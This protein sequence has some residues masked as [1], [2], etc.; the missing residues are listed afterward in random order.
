MAPALADSSTGMLAAGV[1][2]ALLH[3]LAA[4]ALILVL[5]RLKVPLAAAILAGAVAAGLLFRTAPLELLRILAVGAIQ[6]KTL[7]LLAIV[8]ILLVLSEAMRQ[9]GRLEEI[10]E[11]VRLLLRR[12]AAAMAALPAVIGLLPMPGGALFSAP[13]VEAAAGTDRPSGA[14][15]SA[16]NYWYRHIW[17]FWWPLYPGVIL[18]VDISKVGW[19]A[20]IA[21][22]LPLTLF[23]T[24]GGLWTLRALHPNLRAVGP[25]APAGTKRR[26]LA[27]ASPIWL[28]LVIWALLKLVLLLTFG[29]APT[30]QGADPAVRALHQYGPIAV[31]L[32]A[33]LAVTARQDRLGW[34]GLGKVF[35]TKRIYALGVLVLAVRVFQHVLDAVHAPAVIGDE[36]EALGVPVEL[37][38]ALLPFIAGL[39]TGLAV[40]FV[41]TS[42]P[43]VLGLVYASQAGPI[44]P[45]VVLAYA[46][47]HLGQMMSPLHLCQVVSNRYFTT[48]SAPVYRRILPAAGITAVAVAAYF[49]LLRLLL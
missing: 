8:V 25:L 23:M 2:D 12:P 3:T 18:A 15:L 43:I 21:F 10:V 47:G 24:L 11:R 38:V 26:L 5:A 29:A 49:V 6:P 22:N 31:A 34:R 28:V 36:L 19:G 27:A 39:V 40:G 30:G 32:V 1:P 16:V 20:F 46:C 33:S 37:V 41:G 44:H 48:G 14:A 35:A 17:E 4:F 9:G 13:M 45:Y 42:F 7:G